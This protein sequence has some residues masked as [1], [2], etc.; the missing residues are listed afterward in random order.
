[1][2]FVAAGAVVFLAW[3]TMKFHMDNAN[4][5]ETH[6]YV[7]ALVW[8]VGHAT[9]SAD[10]TGHYTG[11]SPYVV[12][13][14]ASLWNLVS[15]ASEIRGLALALFGV[16]LAVYAL[17]FA[18]YRELGLG[19]L[20]SLLGLA[21]L[22]I[23]IVFAQLVQGWEIDKL[24]EPGLFLL[25]ALAAWRRQYVLFVV[26]A[27]LAAANRETGVFAP[28]VALAVLVPRQ[29]SWVTA[30]RTWPV[31]LS[32]AICLIEVICLR[33][34]LPAPSVRPFS[35]A[36]PDRLVYI[37]GGMCLAPLLAIVW[38]ASAP[39][40]VRYL[41]YLLGPIWLVWVAAT[42]HLEQGA[43][44]L[45]PLAV[46][47]VPIT[48]AGL[49]QVLRSPPLPSTPARRDPP[50]PDP[51]PRDVEVPAAPAAPRSVPAGRGT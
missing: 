27:A 23:S 32:A 36:G 37:T 2:R 21:V 44:L 18:W 49:Q 45:A 9:L 26:I 35:D 4:D 43:V 50:Q 40:G 30:L 33:A 28:L 42:D 48:L 3:F 24:L 15:G 46:A 14:C 41:L 7:G 11:L 16:S 5:S 22:S 47:C 34:L 29:G 19:W 10:A 31:W 39:A 8:N 20:M 25:A 6:A 1:V 38:R 13:V 17:A 51:V 12:W